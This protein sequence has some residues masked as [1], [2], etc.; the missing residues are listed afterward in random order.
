MKTPTIAQLNKTFALQEGGNSLR[1]KAGGGD[2]PL[3]E[4][5][6]AEASASISLQGAHVLSW[7]PKGEAE[8]IWVSADA[9]FAPGKSVRGGIPI[10]W[11]WF[12][13]HASNDT[14]PAHGF[15]RTVLWQVIDTQ[16]LSA[17]E[18]QIIFEL[19]TSLLSDSQKAM[20][21]LTTVAEYR[22]T[23]GKHL[24]MELVTFNHS[25]QAITIGQALHTYFNVGD[26]AN[27]TV[28]GLEGKD[29]LDKTDGFKR[30]TQ[31]GPIKINSEVDRI[32]LD[33]ADA[34][35]IDNTKRKIVIK[36][37]GSQSTV[38]WNPWQ[39]LAEKMG[40]LGKDGYR[41]M[42]CVES[43][44]AAEDTIV[45]YADESHTM[46]VIYQLEPG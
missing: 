17:G 2:I 27:T 10:C 44:N 15:A 11:P 14:F 7:I 35:I 29:Y 39:A 21:P 13:A 24:S 12:G 16:V 26:I 40:D 23:V 37:Q 6:N 46:R 31:S 34:V 42:L 4:I 41:E 43:A 33:T 19:D 30:K 45:I 18:T 20:W 22:L 38:I 3:V 9:G 36:K 32:Y 28:R 25:D 1:F 5:V 8:V